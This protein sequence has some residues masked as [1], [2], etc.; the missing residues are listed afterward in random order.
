M[1]DKYVVFKS[2]GGARIEKDSDLAQILSKSFTVVKNPDI[3]K[4]KNISPSF[5]K[6][7]NNEVIE[8]S[9]EEKK[10]ARSVRAISPIDTVFKRTAHLEK[11]VKV[12]L[13]VSVVLTGLVIYIL[14][15]GI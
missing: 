13:A 11:L 4:V 15:K 1:K 5:W 3:S 7:F 9:D 12:S 6:F 8:M 14:V 2:D 10:L